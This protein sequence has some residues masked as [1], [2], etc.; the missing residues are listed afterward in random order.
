MKFRSWHLATCHHYIDIDP[1][2]PYGLNKRVRQRV[3]LTTMAPSRP[4]N[5]FPAPAKLGV[6][7]AMEFA[8]PLLI[9][10][11]KYHREILK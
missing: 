1:M 4:T 6:F 2:W 3:G 7:Q 5:R 9:F 11:L 8:Q 10:D